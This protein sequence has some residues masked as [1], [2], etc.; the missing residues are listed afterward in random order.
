M[1][2]EDDIAT[3]SPFEIEA[4]T[5]VGYQATS[6]LAGTRIRTELNDVGSAIQVVTPEFLEDTGAVNNES[7]LV[8]TTNTEVGGYGGTFGG[9]QSAAGQENALIRPNATNRVRGLFAADNTRN[10]FL[11]DIPWDRYNV[12]RIDLQRGPNAILFGLGSPAGIINATT[13]E[14]T[15]NKSSGRVDARFGSFGSWRATA[16]YNAVLLENELAVR[17]AGLVSDTKFQQEP[18][19]SEDNRY[20][21]SG[22]WEP[23]FLKTDSITTTIKANYEN[24]RIRSNNPRSRPPNDNTRQ[25]FEGGRG[26]YDMEEAWNYDPSRPGSGVA[27]GG[28]PNYNPLV[29]QIFGGPN[30]FY[31]TTTQTDPSLYSVSEIQMSDNF[32]IGPDGSVDGNIQGFLFQR[33]VAPVSYADRA[34]NQGFPY[35]DTLGG[36][37]NQSL[38]NSEVFNFYDKLIDG[39]NKDEYR[40]FDVY[41]FSVG[42][43]FFNNRAGLEFAV[44]HQEYTD[45]R[46]VIYNDPTISIDQNTR[47]A[48][49][50]PNPNVGRPMLFSRA[51]FGNRSFDSTRDSWRLTGFAEIDFRDYM[52]EDSFF[53]K[54]LGRHVFTGLL[55][56]DKIEQEDVEWKRFAPD[57]VYA[58]ATGN[59]DISSNER[60]IQFISYIGGSAL[61]AN[62]LADL[63][64]NP[65][66]G[67]QVPTTTSMRIFDSNWN[68]AGVDPA[69]AWTRPYDGAVLTQSENPANYV[70]WTNLNSRILDAKNGDLAAVTR[71]ARKNKQEIDSY[72][73]VWQGFLLDGVVVPTVG[74][75]NDTAKSWSVDAP[76]TLPGN[77]PNRNDPAYDF[78]SLEDNKVEGDGWTYS[79]VVH[80]P[81]QWREKLPGRTGISLFYN[82]SSNF[83]PAANRVDQF[84]R[85]LG[86]P[87]GNTTDYGFVVQTLDNR[88]SLKVNWYES[89]V[90]GASF[91]PGNMW[92]LGAV[93]TRSWVAAKKFEAGLTGDPAYAGQS[94]NYVPRSG[95]TPEEAVAEQTAHVNGIL[96]NAA[97]DEFWSAWGAQKSETRWMNSAWDPWSEGGFVPQGLTSTADVKSE[98]VEIELTAQP[99][100]NW[101][102]ALNMSQTK[103]SNSNLAGTLKEWV[104]ERNTVFNG[105]AGDIRMWSGAG[106]G[107]IKQQWNNTFYSRYQLA[108]QKE[109]TNVDELREWRMNFVTNYRFK[110][111]FMKNFNIGGS[112]RFEDEVGIGYPII[113][114]PDGD[115]FDIANPYMAPEEHHFDLWVGYQREFGDG[116]Y[117]WR[118]QANVKDLGAGDSLIPVNVQPDGTAAQYRIAPSQQWWITNTLHF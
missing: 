75:R 22:R 7:L 11:T 118:I 32:G 91:D 90:S 59:S 102:I 31:D 63:R 47:L 53:T 4:G 117:R 106:T 80:T 30:V 62:S 33:Y 34:I 52:D 21:L 39:P 109:G 23:R 77:V 116:K 27:Q 16:N 3:L 82:E 57:D 12:D 110:E 113:S 86:A 43:T 87:S 61:G 24:G 69:A 99:M 115:T 64:L 10:F 84:G 5:D 92:F 36:W 88:L 60:E 19:Y 97:P 83:Q 67:L 2:E 58:T 42:S 100:D 25:F 14:A 17:V 26:I 78:A 111:G 65:I 114:G 45:G 94:Y 40:D 15:F 46:N 70:G 85:P 1:E 108:V 18:A 72:A 112:Y 105:P 44:D 98:G 95:Q 20:F 50:S 89:T 38:Q 6:T 81:R 79:F 37:K 93:E 35:T 55:S 96:N 28:S 54:L 13:T 9:D 41:N 104:E 71:L 66:S 49:G 8:Y 56:S 51:N 103:A 29:G 107:S 73:F 101:S 76:L 74:Y 68:A 48:D